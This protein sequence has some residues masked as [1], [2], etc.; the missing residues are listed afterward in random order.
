MVWLLLLASLVS[1]D[2]GTIQVDSG[3]HDTGQIDTGTADTGTA[4][5]ASDTASHDTGGTDT[6]GMDTGDTAVVT[7]L[8]AACSSPSECSSRLCVQ[9]PDGG[10][11]TTPCEVTCA[12]S[13][14]TC[15]SVNGV[16]QCVPRFGNLCRPCA[17]DD[18]CTLPGGVTASCIDTGNGSFCAADCSADGWCPEGYS[19]QQGSCIL[20]QGA[21][22]CTGRYVDEAASTPCAATNDAGT[23]TGERVCTA[24]GL[25]ACDAAVP[26]PETCNGADDNCNGRTDEGFPNL[27]GDPYADCVDSDIDGD[28][29]PNADDGCPSDPNKITP[30]SCGC[31]Q[32]ETNSDGDGG[33]DCID[34]CPLDGNKTVAGQCGCGQPD[35]DTDHDGIAD[36]VDNCPAVANT[37]QGDADGDGV[38][39]ACDGTCEKVV[40]GNDTY[41]F[42][43]EFSTW[44]VARATCLA[45]GYDLA[46]VNDDAE[47]TYLQSAAV[48]RVDTGYGWWIGLNDR[49]TEG[50][51]VWADGS[52]VTYTDWDGGEPNNANSG[53]DCTTVVHL[54]VPRMN[55]N[56]LACDWTLPFLCEDTDADSDGVP[57]AT[58]NCPY[59]YNP[60]QQDTDND[61]IGDACDTGCPGGATPAFS[62]STDQ[63]SIVACAGSFSGQP[64]FTA[65]S[66]AL[67]CQAGWH[68][69]RGDDPVIATIPYATA[70]SFPGCYAVNS[71]YDCDGCYATCDDMGSSLNGNLG[72]TDDLQGADMAGMG[73]ACT[74]QRNDTQTRDSCLATGRLDAA[75]NTFGCYLDP[76]LSGV[77]CCSDAP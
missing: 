27:D 42:C 41:L 72:C 11:C 4:D 70:N 44:D 26:V 69:C 77:M 3:R 17:T 13:G 51:F 76:S 47:N 50:T 75:T 23:C 58:D 20:D 12:E 54:D 37:S 16:D 9:G 61:G 45:H 74:G 22:E 43:T 36:C 56:D 28:G 52:P 68:I 5:T 66:S 29:T 33:P 32:P 18:D 59:T 39:D 25:T 10:L 19:C 35:T 31:G 71:H 63:G 55:W 73:S 65:D 60:Q 6:A 38:G 64:V 24:D 53:E 14:W 49:D 40:N 34:E 2:Q 46:T 1:C 30:G 48:S 67:A 62:Q 57:N 8:G 21:C 15:A 7:D